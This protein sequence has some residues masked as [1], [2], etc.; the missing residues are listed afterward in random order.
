VGPDSPGSATGTYSDLPCSMQAVSKTTQH[1]AGDPGKPERDP[2]ER[3]AN[4]RE[5][6]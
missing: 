2:G 5:T 1:I 3:T 6:N 4:P